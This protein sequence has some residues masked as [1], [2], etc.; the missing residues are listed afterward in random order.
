MLVEHLIFHCFFYTNGKVFKTHE[1][2]LVQHRFLVAV[3]EGFV[4]AAD[5]TASSFRQYKTKIIQAV[6]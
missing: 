5:S 6:Y 1:F 4:Q 3:L 2:L